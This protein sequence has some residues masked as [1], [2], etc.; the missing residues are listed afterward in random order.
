M[1][2]VQT[3]ILNALHNQQV[4]AQY[5]KNPAA[6]WQSI[7]GTL[8][9]GV[10]AA[11]FAGRIASTPLHQAIVAKSTG[12]GQMSVLDADPCAA[13]IAFVEV[14]LNGA[15]IVVGGTGVG[16]ASALV[17][18]FAEWLAGMMASGNALVIGG[19]IGGGVAWTALDLCK[20]TNPP[21]C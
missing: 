11:Q 4:A 5:A 3:G 21:K 8:P 2:D 15:G 18:G 7:G 17:P 6:Y 12:Q 14:L 10:S 19:I 16:I 1:A 20:S 9:P 13:C